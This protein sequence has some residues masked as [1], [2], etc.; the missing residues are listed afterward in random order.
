MNNK[1]NKILKVLVYVLLSLFVVFATIAAFVESPA[2]CTGFALA[3]V[4]CGFTGGICL[5][6]TR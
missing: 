1:I 3:C 2:A 6:A 5:T 4:F